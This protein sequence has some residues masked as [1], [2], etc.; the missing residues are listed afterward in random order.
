MDDNP[1]HRNATCK[2]E[3]GSYD[4]ECNEGFIGSG[5]NCEG[6]LDLKGTKTET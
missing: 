6:K 3:I 4:C 5:E 1:C 2:N